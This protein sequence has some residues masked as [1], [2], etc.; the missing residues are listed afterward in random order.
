[1]DWLEA[2]AEK[3]ADALAKATSDAEAAGE[4]LEVIRDVIARLRAA[5]VAPRFEWHGVYCNPF[6]G[7][8][9]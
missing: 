4:R 3:A 5:E 9:A 7:V 1:M 8:E 6:D 2:E